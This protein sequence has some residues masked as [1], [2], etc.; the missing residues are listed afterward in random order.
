MSRVVC[1]FQ[2]WLFRGYD[3]C[4]SCDRGCGWCGSVGVMDLVCGVRIGVAVGSVGTI[5][6]G[7]VSSGGS[8]SVADSGEAR[9]KDCCMFPSEISEEL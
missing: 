1:L 3:G 9:W 2:A 7:V 6:K 5:G 4:E 8:V